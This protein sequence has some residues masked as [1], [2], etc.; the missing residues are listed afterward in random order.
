ME[1][2]RYRMANGDYETVRRIARDSIKRME[3]LKDVDRTPAA[4]PEVPT[5]EVAYRTA[6]VAS[7]RL[8]DY[9]D[10]RR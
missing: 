2:S 3:Q 5:L 9:A 6:A 1:P 7:Y 8:N 4:G 10:G